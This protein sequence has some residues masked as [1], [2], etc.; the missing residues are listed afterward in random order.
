MEDNSL[1]II[2]KELLYVYSDRHRILI[3]RHGSAESQLM[4]AWLTARR[5]T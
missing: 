5:Y 1:L 4:R 3:G 2:L